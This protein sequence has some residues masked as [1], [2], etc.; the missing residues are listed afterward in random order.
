MAKYNLADSDIKR[1]TDLWHIY[2]MHAKDDG[3][4]TTGNH[5]FLQGIVEHTVIEWKEWKKKLHPELREIIKTEYP[6]LMVTDKSFC[7]D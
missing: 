1:L 5:Y 7:S 4:Q 2:G 3:R 6:Q